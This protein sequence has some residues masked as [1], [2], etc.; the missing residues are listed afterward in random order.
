LLI[1][2]NLRRIK[3]LQLKTRRP[4][5]RPLTHFLNMAL[6]DKASLLMVPSTYEAGKLY[7]VLPSGNRA[8]DQTGENS[9]YDQTRA[10][11]DF[12]RGSNTAATRVNADGLIEKYRENLYTQSNNFSH[13]DWTP[14]AGT[15]TQG[16][17]D[18]NGGTDAW[19]WTASNT[20][21]YLYQAIGTS[22]VFTLSIYAKGVGST[23]GKVLEFRNG[24]TTQNFTLTS[25]WQRFELYAAAGGSNIGFE[26]GNPAVAGDVLHIY[27]AQWETGLVA[28]DYLDSTSVTGK[29]GVLIDL[30]RID[31]S[32]G[33]GALLLEPSRTN[34]LP[35]SE[36]FS[37]T[38][39]QT[40]ISVTQNAST[41]PEGVL[42]AA[43]AIPNTTNTLH[44][45]QE[46]EAVA[47]QVFTF[48]VFAKADGYDW[49]CLENGGE[50]A[51]FDVA[52]G[53]L[54]TISGGTA[55]I[56]DYGNGWYRCVFTATALNNKAF[57]YVTAADNNLTFAG[58]GTSGVYLYGAQF[59]AGSYVSSYIPNHGESG[60]V[61]RA[62]D[63]C[64]N[65]GSA[66]SINSVEGVLYTEITAFEGANEDRQIS[67]SDGSN[68]NR[69]GLQLLANGT[70]IQFYVVS[71][72][73]DIVNSIQTIDATNGIKV[74]FS[75]KVNDF[76]VYV[77]GSLIVTDTS[78]AVP[79]GLNEL[80]FDRGTG[81]D[82]FYGNV[83][84]VAVFNEALSDSEL[85]TLTTL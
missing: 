50:I 36:Y 69:V 58:D 33:A 5:R 67:I 77:N 38:W 25:E 44:R 12:D 82:V 56:E 35:H 18:P 31:Y 24:S 80:A 46:N 22:G 17:E 52:N 8:P 78:G 47:S 4:S 57:M 61:T 32:S 42:N 72:G 48:S 10:D 15:F 40:D 68:S 1:W 65:G 11:F 23:I 71:S 85:A 37:S 62:A 21:P 70:Q 29:A 55:S 19:S 34:L 45:L 83:K 49:I 7:N 6:I 3:T 73:S 30:P 28:T 79:I 20:D 60:G 63:L 41:S 16:I 74:G 43:K 13:S 75:Y 39:T 66:E 2:S 51:F 84:Q 9:G 59:E 54:G 53:E 26:F 81:G 76:K 64:N 14:K 27:A